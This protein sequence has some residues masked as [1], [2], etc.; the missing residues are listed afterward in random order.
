MHSSA[1]VHISSYATYCW[2][3]RG[4]Q[5]QTDQFQSQHC[6]ENP[7]KIMAAVELSKP[8]EC[9]T[10]SVI[11][12]CNCTSQFIF[13]HMLLMQQMIQKTKQ[14]MGILG[15]MQRFN[16]QRYEFRDRARAQE[17]GQQN[18]MKWK[19]EERESLKAYL[20][21]AQGQLSSDE[22]CSHHCLP[23]N[24]FLAPLAVPFIVGLSFSRNQQKNMGMATTVSVSVVFFSF[25]FYSQVFF[26]RMN[27]PHL[28]HPVSDIHH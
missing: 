24:P 14:S 25:L 27:L 7:S 5:Y 20:S 15:F 11:M 23:L 19:R 9:S 2:F 3:S 4:Q 21:N 26:P 13:N 17:W 22:C 6:V 28:V 1:W 18:D 16:G 12:S 8:T 10:L